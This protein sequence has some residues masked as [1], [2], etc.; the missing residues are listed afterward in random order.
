MSLIK[1]IQ[2]HHDDKSQ[3]DANLRQIKSYLTDLNHK[4]AEYE[5]NLS[6]MESKFVD[7]KLE[8]DMKI[9]KDNCIEILEAITEYE[10]AVNKV[11]SAIEDEDGATQ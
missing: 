3:V 11:F 9:I 8:D 5:S 7:K 1:I 2:L 6:E 4:F 10:L